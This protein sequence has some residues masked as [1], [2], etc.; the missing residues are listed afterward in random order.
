MTFGS[1]R[2]SE[3]LRRAGRAWFGRLKASS[4]TAYRRPRL[5]AKQQQLRDQSSHL[6]ETRPRTIEEILG[7]IARDLLLPGTEPGAADKVRYVSFDPSKRPYDLFGAVVERISPPLIK[8]GGA[9]LENFILRT[10]D[11]TAFYPLIYHG[12]PEWPRQIELGAADLGLLTARIGEGVNFIIS[13]GRVIPIADCVVEQKALTPGRR[14]R[15]SAS[16]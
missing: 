4:W 11:G 5:T 9:I 13:D 8:Q 7:P 15:G 3:C 12:D 1:V 14:R 6:I 2:V 16:R 10:P